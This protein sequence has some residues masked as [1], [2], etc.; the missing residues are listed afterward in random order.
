MANDVI[1]AKSEVLSV[2][3]RKVDLPD[4]KQINLGEEPRRLK[5]KVT[6]GKKKDGNLF[7]KILGYVK[8][9]VFEG[10]GDEA[11][12]VG[13]KV[14]AISVH[15]KKGAFKGSANVSSP[16]D[17]EMKTGYLFVRARGLR[18]PK[19]YRLQY[20]KDKEGNIV[21]DDNGEAKIKYPEIWIESDILGCQAFV[22]SQSALDVDDE[23]AKEETVIDA[24]T[25]EVVEAE[26][27][28]ISQAISDEPDE[29]EETEI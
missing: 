24:E 3:S 7:N 13:V 20:E 12:L 29:T 16:E 8:L 14:K 15:F 5:I 6:K 18:I 11:T 19:V 27:E 28:D 10:I 9:P 2:N 17:D 4:F 1:V 21:Y 23:E 22:T 26:D 25:G